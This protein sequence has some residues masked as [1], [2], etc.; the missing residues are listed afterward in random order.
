LQLDDPLP[1]LVPP[2]GKHYLDMWA[3]EDKAS[4]AAES[5][6]KPVKKPKGKQ[7]RADD[8]ATLPVDSY[9]GQFTE[10]V[11]SALMEE[12][13]PPG[14]DMEKNDSAGS[15]QAIRDPSREEL[16]NIEERMRRELCYVGLLDEADVRYLFICS[17]LLSIESC[18]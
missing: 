15:T 9:C 18:S 17:S 1:F 12:G 5:P 2:L 8:A 3:E 7:Q 4:L 14:V 10:R 16:Y 13:V 11:I 6:A